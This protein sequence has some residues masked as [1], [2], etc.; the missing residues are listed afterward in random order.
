MNKLLQYEAMTLSQGYNNICG[1]DEA[2][3]GPLAGPLV[4]AG[5]IM[6][7]NNYI[8]KIND[9]KKL[10][11][12]IRSQLY[13]LIIE[14]AVSY[15]ISVI[16]IEIIE[17]INIL[18]ATKKGMLACVEQLTLSDIVLIDAVKLSIDKPNI[19]IVKGDSLSYSIAAASILAKVYRDNL[20]LEYDKLYPQYNFAENMGY[21]TPQHIEAILTY[22]ACPIHRKSFISK[23][24]NL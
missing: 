10:S 7:N 22:G 24:V 8:D 2:G 14:Q 20:M 3:R 4:V 16:S 21:G 17:E 23:W 18:N 19:S 15:Y 13:K 12:K 11:P 9:S 5:V 1:I 6:P